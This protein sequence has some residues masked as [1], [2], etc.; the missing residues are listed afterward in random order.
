[1]LNTRTGIRQKSTGEFR[2]VDWCP[3]EKAVDKVN[4]DGKEI[5]CN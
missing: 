3:K 2:V 4:N 1:M 5:S